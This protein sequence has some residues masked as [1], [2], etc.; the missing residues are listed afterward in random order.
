MQVPAAP[1]AV[2]HTPTSAA[3]CPLAAADASLA[4]RCRAWTIRCTS[5][6]TGGPDTH[7]TVLVGLP[8]AANQDALPI[9]SPGSRA[10]I[11]AQECHTHANCCLPAVVCAVTADSPTRER[12]QS[13]KLE[14]TADNVEMVLDEVNASSRRLRQP[15][16]LQDCLAEASTQQLA[17]LWSLNRWL[18][19]AVSP[20][21]ASV[22]TSRAATAC[23][24]SLVGQNACLHSCTAVLW[25][26]SQPLQAGL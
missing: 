7:C 13:D 10:C 23:A 4:D 3:H 2:L 11:G 21:A 15:A 20:L 8:G 16:G 25:P 14:L 1:L 9:C 18:L 17:P 6:G 5:P 26:V 24:A 19:A 22:S 12:P